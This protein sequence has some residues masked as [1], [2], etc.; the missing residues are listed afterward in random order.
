MSTESRYTLSTGMDRLDGTFRDGGLSPGSTVAIVG[1]SDSI[2]G[3]LVYNMVADRPTEYI[4]LTRQPEAINESLTTAAD[5]DPN[6]VSVHDLGD[7]PYSA[8]SDRLDELK[9]I[10]ES[11][12]VLDPVNGLERTDSETYRTILRRFEERVRETGSFGIV[13]AVA[14]DSEPANRWQTLSTCSHVFEVLVETGTET[15]D[16]SLAIRKLGGQD[17]L[18][19]DSRRIFPLPQG[20]DLDI[21]ATRNVTP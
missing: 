6:E 17:R 9:L 12:L 4:S 13:H 14:E 2:T 3:T 8:V 11:S 18:R 1:P 15:I 19:E 16:E 7:V 20:L 10:D 5:T 21:G